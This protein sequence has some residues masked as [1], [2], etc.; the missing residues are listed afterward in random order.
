MFEFLAIATGHFIAVASPGPDFAVVMRQALRHGKKAG[1]ITSLGVASGILVHMVYVLLGLV[2]VLK[3]SPWIW[4][5]FQLFAGAYLI[6]LG[7]DSLKAPAFEPDDIE[8]AQRPVFEWQRAFWQGFVTNVLNVKATMFFLSLFTAIVSVHTSV[9]TKAFYGLWM[10]F[11]TAAWFSLVSITF[12]SKS[13]LNRFAQWVPSIE[14]FTGVV[15]LLLG[16]SLWWRLA[17]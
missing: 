1:I 16:L 8:I 11:A 2:Y 5:G 14:R 12:G 4:G 15:L 6:H 7:W 3:A 10:V 13:L 9:L 17:F